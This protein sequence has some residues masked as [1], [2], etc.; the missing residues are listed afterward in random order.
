[1]IY[2]IF[3][4]T[5]ISNSLAEMSV[6]QTRA[7]FEAKYGEITDNPAVGSELA[8]IYWKPGNSKPFMELVEQMTGTPLSA[9][10]WIEKLTEESEVVLKK[11][12]EA[13]DKVTN[14]L[15]LHTVVVFI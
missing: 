7:Y 1:M 14:N 11:E 6:H 10:S 9:R 5:I 2:S 15:L 3:S 4:I 8:D 13:Y 12:R